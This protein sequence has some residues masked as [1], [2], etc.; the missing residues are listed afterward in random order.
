M[1]TFKDY[2]SLRSKQTDCY[3]SWKERDE[4]GKISFHSLDIPS[5][6]VLL[7]IPDMNDKEE[8][9]A[10]LSVC[11]CLKRLNLSKVS[12]EKLLKSDVLGSKTE[13]QSSAFD[14]AAYANNTTKT[15][16]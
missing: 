11:K 5:I 6:I 15:R 1:S 9:F 3:I 14:C 2:Y 10:P 13:A 7:R 4:N 8:L 12:R 16:W